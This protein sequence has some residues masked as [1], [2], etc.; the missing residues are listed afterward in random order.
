M[1]SLICPDLIETENEILKGNRSDKERDKDLVPL[2][3]MCER[4]DQRISAL[5][6]TANQLRSFLNEASEQYSEILTCSRWSV[7]QIS[8]YMYIKIV[9]SVAL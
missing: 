2:A 5:Q 3:D 4:S 6:F 7:Y 1:Q 9:T 8:M